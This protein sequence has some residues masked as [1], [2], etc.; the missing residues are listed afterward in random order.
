MESKDNNWQINTNPNLTNNNIYGANNLSESLVT[1]AWW[2]IELPSGNVTFSKNK[3]DLLGF[4]SDDFK[5]YQDFM[6][7]VHPD[8]YDKTMQAMK[9]LIEGRTNIYRAEYRIRDI[10][11]NYHTFFDF[12][13]I[14]EKDSKTNY[15][16][17]IGYALEITQYKTLLDKIFEQDNRFNAILKALP[18]W[19]FITN[20]EGVYKQFWSIN[21]K[22]LLMEPK[23]FLNKHYSEV[24]PKYI[25]EKFDLCYQNLI[26][27]RELQTTEYEIDFNG[28]IQ[29]FEARFV[30]CGSDEILMI[31]RNITEKQNIYN[32]LFNSEKNYKELYNL[33]R[34]LSNTTTDMIWAKDL[35]GNYLFVNKSICDNLLSATDI[36]EPIGKNDIF[37]AKR[38]KNKFPD[39]PNWHTFGQICVNSDE[40]TLKANKPM[41]FIEHGYIKGVYTYLDVH[42]APLYNENGTLIGVVGTARDITEQIKINERLNTLYQAFEHSQASIAITDS[43]GNIEYVNPAFCIKTGYLESEVIGKNMRILKSG[44]TST[45]EYN[46]MYKK[47][48]SGEKYSGLFLNKKKN[49]EL[50]WENENIAPVK[51][52]N[53]KIT[54]F[55]TVKEDVTEKKQLELELINSLEKANESAKLK[56]YFLANINHELRTPLN[57][58]LGFAKILTEQ[59]INEDHLLMAINILESAKSLSSSLNLIIDL[60][61]LEANK[62]SKQL[63]QAELSDLLKECYDDYKTA[64]LIKKLD[65]KIIVNYK[66]IY[67]SIDKNYF[68]TAVRNIIE[69][70][71]KFTNEGEIIIQ[72]DLNKDTKSVII[73]VKDTGI[74]I[75]KDKF[76]IIFEPFR[77]VSEGTTRLYE[78][79]GLGLS[80][81]KKAIEYLNGFITVNSELNKGSVFTIILPVADYKIPQIEKTEYDINKTKK[82][83]KLLYVEDDEININVVKMFLK[84]NYFLDSASDPITA[85]EKIKNNSYDIILMDINLGPGISGADLAYTIKQFEKYK[86]TPIVAV[87]A[88]TSESQKQSFFEKGCTHYLAKPFMKND[89]IKLL[90]NL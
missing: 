38:E 33:F 69:N 42:K 64:A 90:D 50:F 59:L 27:T 66:P 83:K 4:N 73:T 14:L 3:T 40:V 39:N 77:Q 49:G 46:L 48:N 1:F 78:G 79:T 6:K 53:G 25:A 89:L 74:G 2:I 55:V 12:G 37:F 85:L 24:L 32:K 18:D 65:Y 15:T 23:D 47:L 26:K 70:A 54:N 19:I 31:V 68:T 17:I 20:R 30:L 7:L 13:N 62:T 11:N 67:A 86:N 43:Q 80:L 52:K 45:E 10:N 88:Y 36:E 8:D 82:I 35:N 16:K 44:H 28:D 75:P 41:N 5:H 84:D 56:E 61:N 72:L 87:T 22:Y 9:D 81:A 34:L 21:Y 29:Y 76:D 58:I 63:V 57:S 51:D 60:A 71:I